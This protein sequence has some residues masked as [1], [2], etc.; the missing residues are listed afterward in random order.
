M[1][2]EALKNISADVETDAH[3]WTVAHFTP[4]AASDVDSLIIEFYTAIAS[5]LPK[6]ATKRSVQ[7]EL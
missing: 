4:W 1:I 6:E 3:G 7:N 5:A 2:E